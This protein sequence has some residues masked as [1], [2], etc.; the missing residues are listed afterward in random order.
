MPC[1]DHLEYPVAVRG[2]AVQTCSEVSQGKSGRCSEGFLIAEGYAWI[3]F[4]S[5]LGC[6][7]HPVSDHTAFLGDRDDDTSHTPLK[8]EVFTDQTLILPKPFRRLRR[9]WKRISKIYACR[10]CITA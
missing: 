1:I 3:D 9:T 7:L 4:I 6:C 2:T 8:Q 10:K 5:S